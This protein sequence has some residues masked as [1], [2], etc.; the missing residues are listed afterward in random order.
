VFDIVIDGR[1]ERAGGWVGPQS[2]QENFSQ[3]FSY[4]K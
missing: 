2:L 1:G 4:I 3:P